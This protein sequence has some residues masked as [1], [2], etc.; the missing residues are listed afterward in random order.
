MLLWIS[1]F[2]VGNWSGIPG[3]PMRLGG[4]LKGT[5]TNLCR[6]SLILFLSRLSSRPSS[7]SMTWRANLNEQF[8]LLLRFFT[9]CLA[10]LLAFAVNNP[11]IGDCDVVIRCGIPSWRKRVKIT[12][13]TLSYGR[14]NYFN[15]TY[16]SSV[17]HSW[18]M[19]SW[20]PASVFSLGLG[21]SILHVPPPE[22]Y[23]DLSLSYVSAGAF[24]RRFGAWF[25]WHHILPFGERGSSH[26]MHPYIILYI[27]TYICHP[28]ICRY[29]IFWMISQSNKH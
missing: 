27:Y 5:L 26:I 14:Q 13:I 20:E 18:L 19:I 9:L 1:P 28:K 11:H 3:T 12:S 2:T 22:T 17:Q 10:L 25:W 21:R 7:P 15:G 23:H 6:C 29:I 16:Q 4:C 8:C 24:T